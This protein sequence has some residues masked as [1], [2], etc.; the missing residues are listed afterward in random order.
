MSK[1]IATTAVLLAVALVLGYVE[2]L[3]FHL[4]AIP[5]LKLGLANIT[6]LLALYRMNDRY[7]LG[8]SVLKAV[9]TALLF[10]NPVGMLYSLLGS[11]LAWGGMALGRRAFSVLGVSVIGSVLHNMGQL[12]V[13]CA[14]TQSLAPLGYAPA[15]LLG[16]TVFGVLTGFC[17]MGILR[18]F[19]DKKR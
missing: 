12:A 1:R 6:V 5:G 17:V 19:S 2:A 16:G 11:F 15:L 3:F 9:L 7:A 14:L 8:L 18:A 13:A 10:G 4:P